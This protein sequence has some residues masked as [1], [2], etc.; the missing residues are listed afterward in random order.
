MSFYKNI[1]RKKISIA[2]RS[3]GASPSY[4]MPPDGTFSKIGFQIYEALDLICE[5]PVG[6]L[7]DK[8]GRFLE[9]DHSKKEFKSDDNTVGSST[10][11][12]DKGIYFNDIS[13]REETNQP[14]HSKY[15]VEFRDGAEYQK[16]SSI[17]KTPSKLHKVAAPIKGKYE[18]G[19]VLYTG[20]VSSVSWVNTTNY[21]S[22]GILGALLIFLYRE[23]DDT[24]KVTTSSP[25]GITDDYIGFALKISDSSNENLN[26]KLGVIKEIISDTEINIFLPDNANNYYNA[27]GG[28]YEVLELG[29]ENGAR[30]GT[31]SRDIRREGTSPRDFVEWQRL[32][33]REVLEKPYNYINYDK[34]VNKLTVG[35]QIDGLSDTKSFSTA[36]ENNAGKSKMGTPLPLTV[37]VQAFVGKVDKDGVETI[38]TASFTT[39]SGSGVTWG[40]GDGIISI[41]GIITS[42]YSVSLENI[43]LPVLSDTDIYNFVRIKKV[44]YETYSNLI[45]RDIGVAT[46]TEIND[47]TYVYPNSCYVATSIDSKYFPQVPTRTFRV[48]GKKILIPSNYNPINAD[49]SDRRFSSDQCTRG[50]LIYDGPW[51]GTFKFGWS[52]NPAWIYYDLLI[53]TRYGIGS[54][55]RDVEIVDKWTLYEIGMYCDA[56]T[57]NDGSKTTND[58]GGAGYFIGLDDGFGGLEPRFSCNI[59]IKDQAGAFEALQDLARSFRAMTYFNNSCVTVKVDRPYFFEDFNNLT[60]TAPKENKFPPHLIFNNLNVKD[61]MF[62]YADVDKSTK[63]SAVEVSFLDKK[64]NY[65]S[66]TEY[67]ED[68]EAIKYVGLNFK[69]LDGIGVT[70]RS[71]AHRLA[72]YILFESQ[73]TTE[74]VSFGAGF[75]ALL[76]EPGDIIMVEDEM[77]NF[78][79]NFGTILGASGE[80]N[81]YDPDGNGSFNTLN[82]GKGPEAIIVEPAIGSDQLDYITGGNIHI[83]NPVGKSG[84]E[85]FY[86]NPSANNELYKEIRNPQVISLQIKPG[87]SGLSYDIVDS[88]VAIYINGLNNF[89]YGNTGSQWFSEKDVNIK[90]GSIY[91]IDAS[92]RSPNYYRV[93]NIQEDKE[94]GFN[95]S[96]TIHHTGKFKFVEENIAF[97]IEDDTFKPDLRLTEVIKPNKPASVVTGAFSENADRSLSLPITITDP[98]SGV[99][100]KYIVFLEEP[101]TNVIVSEIFKS[102]SSTTVFTLSGTAKI[103]QIGDYQINVFSENITPAKS[104]S[105][106]A[107]S[108]SFTTQISDFGFT[109]QDNFVEYQNIS[110]NTAYLSSYSNIDETGIAQNSFYENDPNINVVV[111]FEFEDI[112]GGSG[113]SVIEAVNDQIINLK[114]ASGNII[115]NNFKTLSNQSSVTILNSELDNAFGYTGDGRYVMPPSLDFEVSSFELA[116]STSTTQTFAFEQSFDNVPAIFMY[117]IV[118]GDYSDFS[119]PIGRVDSTSSG[120]SVTGVSDRV[121]KYA[122]IA[123]K[124]G[125]FKFNGAS[126]TIQIGNVNNNN[127]SDYQFVN[128]HEDFNTIPKVFIQLQKPDT[129]TETYFS[130]TCITGVS[131]SGF[132]FKSFQSDLTVADGTGLYAYIALDENIFNISSDSELPILSLNYSATGEQAFQFSSDPILEPANGTNNAGLRFN[133]DQYAVMCQRSGDNSDFDDKFFVV[134]RTGNQNR[135]FQHMLETGLE[136]GLRSQLTGGSANHILITG[137]E[138]EINTGNFTLAAWVRFDPNLNG[139]QYLLESHQNGTGVAWFQSGDGKNYLNLNG[140]DYLAATGATTLNDDNLHFLQIVVDRENGLTGYL[141]DATNFNVNTSITELRDESFI[142]GFNI[143]GVGTGLGI[144]EDSN[145]T[146]FNITGVGTGLGIIE[147]SNVTGFN[148]T[149]VGTGVSGNANTFDGDYTGSSTLFQNITT[150]GLRF[151]LDGVKWI[152]TDEDPGSSSFEKIAWEGGDNVDYPWNVTSWTG[153]DALGDSSAPSFSELSP[154]GNTNTFDGDYTGSSPL[155]QNIITSGLRFRLDGAKWILTDENP[156]SI[157]FGG[158]AWEGGDNT[159]YPWNVDS[160]TGVDALGDSSAPSFSELSPFVSVSLDSQTGFKILGN[161]ELNGEAL[162]SGY[163]NKYFSLVNGATVGNYFSDPNSFF[164]AFSGDVNTQFIFNITGFPLLVDASEKTTASLVG[165]VERS[166]EIIN[167]LSSSNFNFMQIGVTGT[168]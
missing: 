36:G 119:K 26:G 91:N 130:D 107:T 123:S 125:V 22:G 64:N 88:G 157:S 76:I 5:G 151:K 101:N 165:S 81:Y 138:L 92:G 40:N 134:H 1:F 50:N 68:T 63:L 90:H 167:R 122:Y 12:I 127:T 99:P 38:Q 24:Y 16:A 23:K 163:I 135:A 48:K 52:D 116:G 9:G 65:K 89:L 142:T 79:K 166:E 155:F 56:V 39:R 43:T 20:S 14:T 111:N 141:D 112:F 83:Y 7:T 159:D 84:I 80:T 140:I 71:Q 160:W 37:T 45:K 154:S 59:L 118:D 93:L 44:E 21:G 147:D 121:A 97:D 161:S 3:K 94:K 117:E 72:K 11:G 58:Y 104:R 126:K 145:V 53:N 109:A 108:V 168:L 102:A 47:Q 75:E 164:T 18:L 78:T 131:T 150:S 133:H 70:S 69:Q 8:K 98:A 148:I 77:R 87:G 158:V 6:G 137:D 25:H 153:V 33:V 106:D 54:H 19:V 35:L 96:A 115:Q 51:D 10:N 132:F 85:D 73:Y 60:T 143:A 32:G 31:G 27:T 17:V 114:D 152:L 113:A 86:R 2:G 110:I 103:D 82:S 49:G 66:A 41:S 162:T 128:F 105:T 29:S 74:T 67:V 139:K 57:M 95:V 156:D 136:P 15:D 42:P 129:T 34:N 124:T 55:L 61:G 4:L 13:L 149:G 120:F 146:G 28:T 62:S 46:I 30:T 100:E 144:I